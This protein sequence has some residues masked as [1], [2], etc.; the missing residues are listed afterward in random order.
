MSSHDPASPGLL[1]RRR[2]LLSM[3]A[4]AATAPLAGCG[5]LSG[6]SD[7]SEEEK[8]GGKVEKSTINLGVL[9]LVDLAPAY[10][11]QKRGYFKEEGLTIKIV[12]VASGAYATPKLVTGE[13][14][15]TWNNWIS[16]FLAQAEGAAK[17]RV[18][19]PGADA[20]EDYYVIMAKP[21]SGIKEPKDLLGKTI[22]INAPRNVVELTTRA[23][24]RDNGVD[25]NQVTLTPIPFPDMP[26]ALEQGQVDAVYLLEP[27]LTQVERTMGAVR[28]LD[29]MTG[30]TKDLAVAGY[31][32]TAEFAD[33]NPNTCAAF[34]RAMD[35]ATRAVVDRK[36]VE[37]ILP[38]YIKTIDKEVA[39]L[40]ALPIW[41]TTTNRV[42]LQRVADLMFQFKFLENRLDVGALL[43]A[44]AK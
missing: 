30:P 27:F 37:D 34:A 44:N 6:S 2:L 9:P 39:Q 28:V 33:K 38:T 17:L 35:K 15:I 10:L 41:P 36:L 42:R 43:P 40:M 11:A 13:L 26:A 1:S 12:P 25:D 18:V 14:D 24:L 19:A 29:C 3:S 20:P 7:S 5:L 23:A 32:S 4:L 16:A 22:A 21:D 31:T 8:G